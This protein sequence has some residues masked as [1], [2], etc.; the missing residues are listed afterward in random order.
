MLAGTNEQLIQMRLAGDSIT[1][2]A[3]KQIAAA[4]ATN[5][6]R[7]S[8][9]ECCLLRDIANSPRSAQIAA[10]K[11]IREVEGKQ[12]AMGGSTESGN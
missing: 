8:P 9:N 6:C 4:C 5:S 3:I 10:Y 12:A 11:A 2:A 7:L 1:S